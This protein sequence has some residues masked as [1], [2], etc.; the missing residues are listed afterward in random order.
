[1][2]RSGRPA[3]AGR[4][5][6]GNAPTPLRVRPARPSGH[7]RSPDQ[8]PRQ[9]LGVRPS[10]HRRPLARGLLRR[11]GLRHLRTR[12]YTPRTNGKAERL[13]QTTL[14]EWAYARSY[15]CIEQRASAFHSWL[16]HYSWLAPAPRQPRLQTSHLPHPDEQRAGFTQ[17]VRAL[18][19]RARQA[20]PWPYRG[21]APRSR[22]TRETRVVA[23]VR[24]R[25]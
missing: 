4:V 18:S 20:R 19:R 13:V 7:R 1:M 24:W 2:D 14:R 23:G 17:P 21:P 22:E 9:R 8:L 12:P 5:A 16:H 10:G 15:P 11:L 3:P 6:A 25:F